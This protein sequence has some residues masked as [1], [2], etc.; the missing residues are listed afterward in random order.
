MRCAR[1][2]VV[3][4]FV[5]TTVYEHQARKLPSTQS[6]GD[7]DYESMGRRQLGLLLM[8]DLKPGD[9]L[10]DFGCG[11]GRL[12]VHVIHRLGE[13]GRYIGIDISKTML[14][15][16]RAMVGERIP[17]PSCSIEFLH[18]TTPDFR[19]AD[20]SIDMVCAFS[21]FTHMEHEDSYL[22]LQGVRR[23]IKDGGRFIYSC[24]PMELAAA[25]RIFKEQASLDRV[26]R[27]IDVRNVTTSRELMDAIARMAGW[28][29]ISWYP[30]DQPCIRLPD[31]S[32]MGALGQSTCV[33]APA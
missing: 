14:A 25:R 24:L 32:E 26:E 28:E 30:G 9:T 10:L 4:F 3:E 29:P 23:I 21:V 22:Y 16:A 5:E 12:A 13:G 19:L 1:S 6:I 20:K 7:G 11:T 31:S 33:L 27:W 2:V 15:K 17:S 8:E 18:Q